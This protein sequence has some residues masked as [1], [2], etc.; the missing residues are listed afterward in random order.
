MRA[1]RFLRGRLWRAGARR[2]A[3]LKPISL[4]TFLF[5]NKKVTFLKKDIYEEG[6]LPD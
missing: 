5:G 1:W 2:S 3:P 6:Y 4:V